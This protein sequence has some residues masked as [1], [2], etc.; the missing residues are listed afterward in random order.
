M[1]NG[2]LLIVNP[3]D[4]NSACAVR[5]LYPS[6]TSQQAGP[7]GERGVPSVPSFHSPGGRSAA[8]PSACGSPH[9]VVLRL[10]REVP[11]P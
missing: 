9:R 8:A 4:K 5:L 7:A 10:H 6:L 3:S 1:V 11:L 2:K